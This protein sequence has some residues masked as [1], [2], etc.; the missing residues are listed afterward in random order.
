M[1]LLLQ[2]FKHQRLGRVDIVLHFVPLDQVLLVEALEADGSVVRMTDG[3]KV[4]LFL[5]LHS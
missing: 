5:N 1:R 3:G 2:S 4:G